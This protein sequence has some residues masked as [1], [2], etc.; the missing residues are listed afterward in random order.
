MGGSRGGGGF[1]GEG[2]LEGGR[3]QRGEG[4]RSLSAL[5][6]IILPPS[7]PQLTVV[8][9]VDTLPPVSNSST[10]P[11]E[12]SVYIVTHSQHEIHSLEFLKNSRKLAIHTR[13]LPHSVQVSMEDSD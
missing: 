12:L 4:G 13:T 3:V 7:P 6:G 1:R 8:C 10:F 2:G 9:E 11:H 5:L